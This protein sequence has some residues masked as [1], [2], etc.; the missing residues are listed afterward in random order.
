MAGTPLE[1][2]GRA[3]QLVR[4]SSRLT[5]DT[6]ARAATGLSGIAKHLEDTERE[7]ASLSD[8]VNH[9]INSV[10]VGLPD[11]VMEKEHLIQPLERLKRCV[12]RITLSCSEHLTKSTGKKIV[13][14]G[15]NVKEASAL[16]E[17]FDDAMGLFQLAVDLVAVVGVEK[18]LERLDSDELVHR[19]GRHVK[20]ELLPATRGAGVLNALP[21]AIGASWD[22]DKCCLPGT[23]EKVFEEIWDWIGDY[24]R[25][26]TA[27]ILWIS[28]VAG[29]GKSAIAHSLCQQAREKDML[30]SCFFFDR[31]SA[32]RNTPSKLISTLVRDLA[33]LQQNIT[34]AVADILDNDPSLCSASITRQFDCLALHPSLISK[35]PRSHCGLVIFDGLDE[36][37]N[38]ALIALLCKGI[39]KLP[40]NFRV[41]MTSRPLP[42]LTRAFQHA[43]HIPRFGTPLHG[44]EVLG[45][46][47]VFVC[48]RFLEMTPGS[49]NRL[50]KLDAGL[51]SL[52]VRKSEGLFQWAST[53]TDFIIR[54]NDPEKQS[55][56]IHSIVDSSAVEQQMD[57]LYD[58]ILQSLPWNYRPFVLGYQRAVGAVV[59]VREPISSNT[60]DE[61]YQ[62]SSGPVLQQL[63]ALMT[64]FDSPGQ[65]VRLLHLSLRDYLTSRAPDLY[66]IS[67]LEHEQNLALLCLESL[68]CRLEEHDIAG[69]VDFDLEMAA[70]SPL[71]CA[72]DIGPMSKTLLYA[73]NFWIDH[74]VSG[75]N[76]GDRVI[77]HLQVFMRR[78]FIYWLKVIVC[79][80]S[81][82]SLETLAIWINNNMVHLESW[83]GLLYNVEV[84]SIL[85]KLSRRLS[86]NER[87][88][89]A[90]LT[91][92]DSLMIYERMAE[93]D[94]VQDHIGIPEA[95]HANA[96][97]VLGKGH[98]SDAL[99]A[100]DKALHRMP[101]MPGLNSLSSV[102]AY[103]QMQNTRSGI[104]NMMGQAVQALPSMSRT[105]SICH[106]LC[107]NSPD[108]FKQELYQ[109][110]ATVFGDSRN[111]TG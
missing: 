106:E 102:R 103:V 58:A 20:E 66:R 4:T 41:I 30:W 17:E 28:D 31:M 84:A 67:V 56:L 8:Y 10:L 80:G 19:V 15:D 75:N 104:L 53:A 86:G 6:L 99:T 61:L 13:S 25:A 62:I 96:L 100:I 60:L 37:C 52:L 50:S 82:R 36:A 16:R 74:L 63:G 46:M 90:L 24:D 5:L 95:F 11:G 72:E 32:E 108:Q 12:E 59:V 43:P 79:L 27:E 83:R 101:T 34:E 107:K 45:D 42:H 49:F 98:L 110:L 47:E 105:V 93:V 48:S 76:A 55:E 57:N 26:Q 73:C 40:R 88:H 92:Q 71:P 2:A 9:R 23:R 21:Y 78:H 51:V 109:A 54:C 38:K 65:A 111:S 81:Y 64:G 87:Y 44:S 18:L 91:S 35:Y 22:P 85:W 29:S 69:T 1:F 89:D 7:W 14:S 77:E 97:A 33:A 3:V 94:T 70:E 39:R 68:N